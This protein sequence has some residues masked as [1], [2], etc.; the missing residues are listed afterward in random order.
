[1]GITDVLTLNVRGLRN[2]KK[3]KGLFTWLKKHH[4]L[5]N[6]IVLLQETHSVP[7]DENV[8][9]NELGSD[10]IFCHGTN[11]SR[12]TCIL[13][14]NEEI[15]IVN[16][17]KCNFGRYVGIEIDLN[18]E[19]EDHL[20]IMNVYFPTQ[21]QKKDQIQMTKQISEILEKYMDCTLVIGGDFNVCF[22]PVLDKYGDA[23]NFSEYRSSLKGL[24]DHLNVIDVWRL[25]NPDVR[26]YTWRQCN[27]LRQSRLDYIF[28]SVHLMYNIQGLEILPSY[29]SD[30]SLVK[31]SLKKR[32][33][34]RRG[35]G[36]W[37]FN[38]SLLQDPIYVSYINEWL[39]QFIEQYSD[40][41][42]K[43][44]VW[45]IIKCE[46]RRVTIA[47]SK[48]Q[49]RLQKQLL[50][51]LG[52]E[53]C[54]LENEICT[55]PSQ[56]KLERY[57][58]IKTELDNIHTN[59]AFGIQL[60]SKAREVEFGEKNSKYFSNLEKSRSKTKHITELEVNG[61]NITNPD[62]ILLEER[63][64]Y[65]D[66]YRSRETEFES[67]SEFIN[68]VKHNGP[69]LSEQE[70]NF[71]EKNITIQECAKALK[72]L[73][74][75]KSPGS[76]GFT[77]EFYKFFWSRISNLVYESYT[78]AFEFGKMSIEQRRTIITLIPK[79]DKIVKLLKN[80]RPISLLNVDFKIL[81][82]LFGL[83]IRKVLPSIISNDQVGYLE[84][85][86]IGQNIRLIKD[87]IHAC[88]DDSAILAF[89]DF[90]KAFDSIEWDFLLDS[91]KA[92]NFG[93]NF[94]SWVQIL[95][96]DICA[97]VTNNGF[98]SEFF[99]LSR[100]VRQGC[101][102]SPY[103]FIIAA[104][105][106]A[107]KIKKC[108][109][110]RGVTINKKTVKIVQMAD[111][112]TVFLKDLNSFKVLLAIMKK[113]QKAAG[114]KLNTGKTEA[115][116]L[117]N[118][119]PKKKELGVKWQDGKIFSLGFWFCKDERE[120]E[121]LNIWNSY[122]KCAKTLEKWS[123]RKL[124]VKGRITVIKSF[125]LP[126]LLYIANNIFVPEEFIDKVNSLFFNFLWEG[127]PDKVKRK[128][129]ILDYKHGGLRMIDFRSM[130]KAMKAMWV[131]RIL[132]T[133]N[134]N[135]LLFLKSMIKMDLSDFIKCNYDV[136]NPPFQM[137]K[138]YE[139]IFSCWTE[140]KDHTYDYNDPECIR[141]QMICYNKFLMSGGVY[142]NQQWTNKLYQENIKIIHD[143]C[144]N[145]ITM[146]F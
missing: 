65:E 90:E 58:M 31:L 86:Y 59:I 99:K 104:E 16:I 12:G 77:A 112:T 84:G 51:E 21:D 141:R 108:N 52:D 113:F 57:Q 9:K 127:K 118:N 101:P 1:M 123:L 129:I 48:T 122:E 107:L 119:G 81:A 22:D 88:K 74:N 135:W 33:T 20:F 7:E 142:Y 72:E 143:I 97:C 117:G 134:A 91:L 131:K 41:T 79:K 42:N 18:N 17:E 11:L 14:P 114:L 34:H 3:R 92:F 85:R 144:Y 63:K 116:Y 13:L 8:W 136:S 40:E 54:Q 80:W 44:N 68:D 110:I 50:V 93:Y 28:T 10:I 82:K 87:V 38:N 98:S 120:D 66:L 73:P 32:D 6:S 55:S 5:E 27:P 96:R 115:M 121:L 137:T 49:S 75:S 67:K 146:A 95:Y 15:K 23:D 70:R 71:M 47:Y 133:H 64:F 132:Q 37:K 53:I 83:R 24:C 105:T 78:Y 140:A 61:K 126:K 111:D 125:A 139:Q 103:L 35:P 43:S 106:L 2:V 30:H 39:E 128:A 145:V 25:L 36:F 69:K 26:R 76:D 46:I 29:K 45:D 130:I 109:D 89:L 4:K 60:R 94:T 124:S 102:L 138:F 56:D 62:D 100:G 19:D